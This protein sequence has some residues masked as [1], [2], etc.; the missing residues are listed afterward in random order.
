MSRIS[1]I[2]AIFPFLVLAFGCGDGGPTVATDVPPATIT[3][4]ADLSKGRPKG[5]P[6]NIS[7][8]L[9]LDPATGRPIQD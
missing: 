3:P 1:T 8:G 2:G 5:M 7:A 9:K 4:A 6:K